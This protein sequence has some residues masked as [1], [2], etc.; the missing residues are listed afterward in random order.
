MPASSSARS[1]IC[2][3][4]PTNGLP[5]RS[6]LS[7][8]CSPTSIIGACAGPSPN[9][10]WVA[11]FQSG[12]ARQ[13]AASSRRACR[14]DEG[15]MGIFRLFPE[16]IGP[17]VAGRLE[18]LR[19]HWNRLQKICLLIPIDS[20]GHVIFIFTY[21]EQMSQLLVLLF[22]NQNAGPTLLRSGA[23]DR[24]THEHACDF[25]RQYRTHRGA[26]RGL[27]AVQGAARP[28]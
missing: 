15:V 20:H 19:S 12:Q 11:S 10:V 7:P 23:H 17:T 27:F 25:A 16:S 4:G 14:L 22:A 6:S 18:P 2:P 13:L 3:A 24:R 5:A 21:H 9:T 8:G 28:C 1:R 26:W